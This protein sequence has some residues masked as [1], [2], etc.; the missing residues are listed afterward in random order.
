VGEVRDADD[1]AEN[2]KPDTAL[3]GETLQKRNIGLWR[4]RL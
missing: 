4:E 3:H 1:H 2:E